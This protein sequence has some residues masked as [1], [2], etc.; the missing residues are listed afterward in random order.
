[1]PAT[2]RSTSSVPFDRVVVNLTAVDG[3][4][5]VSVKDNTGTPL[6]QGVVNRGNSQTFTSKRKITL[7][8]GDGGQCASHRQR[9]PLRGR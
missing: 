1:M 5:Y 4:S 7:V 8:I 9:R 3:S 6:Y 2:K